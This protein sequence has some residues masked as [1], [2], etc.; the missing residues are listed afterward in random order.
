MMIFSCADLIMPNFFNIANFS[1][2]D[3][4][5]ISISAQPRCDITERKAG[6]RA[7][8]LYHSCMADCN[9]TT[10]NKLLKM[11]IQELKLSVFLDIFKKTNAS[12]NMHVDDAS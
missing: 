6:L 9:G 2:T 3:C 5:D 11:L 7:V 4:E 8:E 10:G 1:K 12:Y